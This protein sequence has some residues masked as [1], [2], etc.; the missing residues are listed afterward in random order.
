[1]RLDRNAIFCD[2]DEYGSINES[3]WHPTHP[4]SRFSQLL[5]VFLALQVLELVAELTGGIVVNKKPRD[6]I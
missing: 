1:M 3:V 4:H 6:K 2:Q 5:D